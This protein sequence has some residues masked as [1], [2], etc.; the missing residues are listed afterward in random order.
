M[1]TSPEI[2]RYT[3]F[4]N[5]YPDHRFTRCPRCGEET[6]ERN[7]VLVIE[8]GPRTVLPAMATCRFCAHCDL[9]IAHQDELTATLR[10]MLPPEEQA[11]V[12]ESMAIL[13]TL[14]RGLLGR[15]G[16]EEI[17]PGEALEAFRPV[18]EEVHFDLL[19]DETGNVELIER[20]VPR[21][22]KMADIPVPQLADVQ[23][24]PQVEET[25]QLAALPMWTWI[26]EEEEE[27]YRPYL[28]L[29]VSTAGPLMVYQDMLK[30]EPSLAEVRD[31][32]L[33]AMGHP[34]MGAGE[35]RRPTV[36]MVDEETL[37]ETLA[38]EVAVLDIHCTVGDTPELDVLLAELEYYLAD[39]HEP[40][41]GLLEDPRVAPEQVGE[42][43][44]AAADFYR[45]APWELMLDEDLVALR[46][47]V[48]D[49]E[50]RFV[51]VMGNAGLEYGLAVFSDLFDYELLA[52]TPPEDLVGMMDYRSLTYDDI[53]AMPFADLD[54]LEHYGWEIAADDAYPIPINFTEDEELLRPGPEE[55]EWYTVAL[56]AVA[57][58]FREYW[59]DSI[60]YIPESVATTL[61]VPVADR[62][63]AVE[64]RYPAD[65]VLEEE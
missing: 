23:A 30:T 49:G 50:W 52:S 53:T 57:A 56:R 32:L 44:E 60:D 5:P 38:P 31:A 29:I 18:R 61:T 39:G 3:V 14:D 20:A 22:P 58:F 9:L 41:P 40:V 42:L 45:E 64:L 47:P 26:T 36:L 65:F 8:L 63:V 48:P 10:Q 6:H 7:R 59:P 35:P 33:K 54:A 51:S 43:F 15:V 25:W 12:G 1:A 4:L 55:V 13:G 28:V 11:S 19:Q 17:T 16:L 24:L 21:R 2:E 27:P 46:Y 62:H 34:A 37:A